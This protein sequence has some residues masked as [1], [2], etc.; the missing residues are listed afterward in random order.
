MFIPASNWPSPLG[1]WARLGIALA[2]L[3]VLASCLAAVARAQPVADAFAAGTAAFAEQD[4]LRALEHFE[5]ARNAGTDGPA[6]HYNIAVC[7]YRLA[8]YAEAAEAFEHVAATYP[9]MRE[10]ARYNLGLVRIRQGRD[11]VARDLFV[12]VRSDSSDEKLVALAGEALRRLAPARAVE[13][14]RSVWISFLDFGLGYDDN[15][16]LLDEASVPATQSVNSAF[17]EFLGVLTGPRRA[18]AG[19]RFDGTVYAVRHDDVPEFDQ[20]ALRVGG[21]YQWSVGSWWLETGPHANYSTLDGDGFEQRVGASFLARRAL[22]D[23]LRLTLRALHDEVEGADAVFEFLDGSRQ[24]L[25]ASIDQRTGSGRISAGLDIE[26]NDRASGSVSPDR[27]RLWIGYRY[28]ADPQWHA[29]VRLALRTSDYEDLAMP[30]T[31]DLVNLDVGYTRLLNGGWELGGRVRWYD[32][33]TAVAPFDYT[34]SRLSL[35]LTK[36]F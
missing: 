33:D 16:A 5:A 29:D 32:N 24:Q 7:H 23:S 22:T 15:V 10:L 25:S 21:T 12:E 6:I 34:R 36:N 9:A 1:R 31:E 4:Y 30:R 20:T 18:A 11:A 35:S 8:Q 13:A 17:T 26:R 27:Q 2:V 14:P 28:T 3:L 19:F